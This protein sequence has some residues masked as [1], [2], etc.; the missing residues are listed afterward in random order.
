MIDTIALHTELRL[1]E[2]FEAGFHSSVTRI[3]PTL[4]D[5]WFE[6]A[7]ARKRPAVRLAVNFEKKWD[8]DIFLRV[9][10]ARALAEALGHE[11]LQI[12][13]GLTP[14]GESVILAT[15]GDRLAIAILECWLADVLRLGD[16]AT[17]LREALLGAAADV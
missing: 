1:G 9:K 5:L 14:D 3:D 12:V 7:R 6:V 10:D 13:T 15:Q 8:A 2:P 16:S 4:G 17:Q 11:G